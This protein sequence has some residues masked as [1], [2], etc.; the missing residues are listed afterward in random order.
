MDGWFWTSLIGHLIKL[1]KRPS[2]MDYSVYW[3][4]PMLSALD[5]QPQGCVYSIYELGQ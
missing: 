4:P 1:G 2:K 3:S 5:K